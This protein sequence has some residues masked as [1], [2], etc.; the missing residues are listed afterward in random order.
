MELWEIVNQTDMDHPFHVH[1]SQFQVV[2]IEEKGVVAPY[3]YL[4]WKNTINSAGQTVRLKIKQSQKGL[5]MH[6]CHTLEHEDLGMMGQ[7]EVV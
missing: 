5:R 1:G 3:P 4:A 6:H 7:F 2:S